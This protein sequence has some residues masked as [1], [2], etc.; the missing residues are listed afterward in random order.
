[1][2]DEA[3]PSSTVSYDAGT[4]SFSV[5]FDPDSGSASDALREA[6]SAVTERPFE[7]VESPGS[8]VDPIVFDALFKR[9]RREIKVS[10]VLEDH[11]IVV[12]SSGVIRISPNVSRESTTYT[13]R[14]EDGERLSSAVRRAIGVCLDTEV[15]D[16][17]SLHGPA[18]PYLMDELFGLARAADVTEFQFS[19]LLGDYD[20]EAHGDGR[21]VV[22]PLADTS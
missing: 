7:S 8:V 3:F 22:R 5:S 11:Q 12:D 18:N 13:V 20:V 4:E 9:R 16:L 10:F 6:V 17:T 1:M 15:T 2:S 21:V 19:F 14:L